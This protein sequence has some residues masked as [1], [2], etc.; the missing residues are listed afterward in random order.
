MQGKIKK[1]KKITTKLTENKFYPLVITHKKSHQT[2]I[3]KKIDD[4]FG[5]GKR[6][7]QDISAKD[8]LQLYKQQN[9]AN[10]FTNKTLSLGIYCKN[11][12]FLDL[13]KFFIDTQ[14]VTCV[15]KKKEMAKAF[16]IF[17]P[18]FENDVAFPSSGGRGF[19]LPLPFEQKTRKQITV[20]EGKYKIVFDIL[21][22]HSK[23][24]LPQIIALNSK[25]IDFL[26]SFK[27]EKEKLKQIVEPIKQKI[28]DFEKPDFSEA[29]ATEEP[30]RY[31]KETSYIVNLMYLYTKVNPKPTHKERFLI[32]L[33]LSAFLDKKEKV[34]LDTAI[35][36]FSTLEGYN[37]QITLTNVINFQKGDKAAGAFTLFDF[38]EKAFKL[39]DKNIH[40]FN[41]V[42]LKTIDEYKADFAK[43]NDEANTPLLA[44]VDSLLG[45]ALTSSNET[46]T[47]AIKTAN[48]TQIKPLEDAVEAFLKEDFFDK[49]F[50]DLFAYVEKYI[51]I[52]GLF[53]SKTTSFFVT[54]I[55]LSI[56]QQHI[57]FKT[58]TYDV[59][60]TLFTMFLARSGTGKATISKG[61]R[62]FLSVFCDKGFLTI[63]GEFSS[64]QALTSLLISHPNRNLL[65]YCDE[66]YEKGLIPL[67]IK[68]E[69]KHTNEFKRGIKHLVL[70]SFNDTTIR[71]YEAMQTKIPEL[72][73][74]TLSLLEF[75]QPSQQPSD[76]DFGKGGE[77]RVLHL[78]LQKSL[79][80]AT[81]I[82][83]KEGFASNRNTLKT[84]K[85]ALAALDEKIKKASLEKSQYIDTEQK[86]Q[87]KQRITQ[88]LIKKLIPNK[89]NEL[90]NPAYLQHLELLT[91]TVEEFNE[92]YLNI[93]K[94]E[95]PKKEDLALVTEQ[96]LNQ[97]YYSKKEPQ[98]IYNDDLLQ[99]KYTPLRFAMTHFFEELN[100]VIG[101]DNLDF[102][103]N[104]SSIRLAF[105]I[106]KSI[107][108]LFRCFKPEVDIYKEVFPHLTN[109][110]SLNKDLY[111][112]IFDLKRQ[113][114]DRSANLF[115]EA[116][117]SDYQKLLHF[118]KEH[119]GR[120]M[121]WTDFHKATK[122]HSLISHKAKVEVRDAFLQD[123]IDKEIIKNTYYK[124]TQGRPKLVVN[125]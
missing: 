82:D 111:F 85:A 15:N 42:E 109:I 38:F 64:M 28:K 35:A 13:D 25:T 48:E 50:K 11:I 84:T 23:G 56:M 53:K 55:I 77:N 59:H 40:I 67:L 47:A 106:N 100:D 27:T 117:H 57:T 72:K 118:C 17:K 102:E 70:N 76:V 19:H 78:L 105:F 115:A 1:N 33:T 79:D 7:L 39:I 96:Y 91:L 16:D 112:S 124:K 5:P 99:D 104:A 81:L 116:E 29:A 2:P 89:T 74:V 34:F 97:H 94:K 36:I 114:N 4:T 63:R 58:G 122:L 21:G 8:Y 46:I 52:N 98:V 43:L 108:C 69:D 88:N 73:G 125:I 86:E 20:E 123:L 31:T 83:K 30:V 93:P 103:A 9:P 41:P 10:P 75:G 66:G 32:L 49:D 95:N 24:K 68:K 45:R 26:C 37:H 101:R 110:F 120:H 61:I 121:A 6:D 62:D 60:T 113:F 18:F 22:V 65:L 54:L 90:D 14:E 119:A 3:A 87:E 12:A 80:T 92:K 44:Q 107:C 51:L 71:S